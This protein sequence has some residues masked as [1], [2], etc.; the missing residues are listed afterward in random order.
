MRPGLAVPALAVLGC[1][2]APAPPAD[3]FTPA[4]REALVAAR[5]TVWRAWFGG[6]S[7]LMRQVL[8]D[9]MVGMGKPRAEIIADGVAFRANGGTLVSLDFTNDEFVVRDRMAL[10]LSDYH[11]VTVT[12]GVTDTMAGRA[13]E[14]FTLEGGRWLNP[15]WHLHEQ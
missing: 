3:A 4:V 12:K 6:D 14:V 1:A 7:V 13:T 5:D 9:P 11:V 8:P 15:Y 10:V 2:P